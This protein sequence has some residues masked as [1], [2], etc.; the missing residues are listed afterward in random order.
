M[1]WYIEDVARWKAERQG[2]EAFGA[3]T[4]W[5]EPLGW[6]IDTNTRLI[7]DANITAGGM[8]WPVF[9]R[10][11]DFF[12]HSPP[13]VFP[14]G[15]DTRWSAHQYGP[16]GELCLEY[17]PDT[18]TPDLTGVHVME[19]AHRLLQG[20]NPAPGQTGTV[21]SRH[22]ES[23]GEQFR[24]K[25]I[26]FLMTRNLVAGFGA[27][28]TG[29][30]V[31][32]VLI[33]SHHKDSIIHTV[34]QITLGDGSIWI[35]SDVPEQL[36]DEYLSR[37]IPLTRIDPAT[38]LPPTA[39]RKD[40]LA[41]SVSFDFAPDGH[42]AIILRGDEVH[43]YML[44]ESDDWAAEVPIIPPQPIHQR[45]DETHT[46]L[47]TKKFGLVGC[48]SLG[49]KI[50]AMLARSGTGKALLVDDD[51]LLADNLARHDLDWRDVGT[52]KVDAVARRLQLANP[53]IETSIWKMRIGGQT[54]ASSAETIIN[55]LGECDVIIDA[56]A[57]PNVLNLLSALG[58]TK[59]K[60]LV[61]GEVFGGGIGGLIARFRPGIEPS[62]QYMRR[63][64][65][66]WFGEQNAPPVRAMRSYE[67]G[68]DGPPLIADDADV[69]VIAAHVARLAIDL[70]AR[71][72]SI[73]PNSVYAVGLG[74]GS[75][76]TQ[77][78]DTRPINVGPPPTHTVPETLGEEDR[79]AEIRKIVELF[80]ALSNEAPVA[81][82][83]N[84]TPAA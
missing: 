81:S 80:I 63:A 35:E 52:H 62:P 28:Q 31:S 2:L 65:E 9:L 3:A 37:R 21:P 40:F 13:S 23:I 82:T 66:N 42:Y 29:E 69:S 4:E 77:P 32:A 25:N 84:Q 70:L 51:L 7:L 17:G 64:I 26:R 48:G 5:F 74:A 75:V 6:R 49:S 68:G 24:R 43:H 67:T 44:W 73:F 12:P 18:W 78:F 55:M 59:S 71:D 11:P 83:D 30:S 60:P 34:Q 14:R 1:T 16:G 22:V 39:S 57:N 33:S 79:K 41:A 20:E 54:S 61:W 46:R 15:D 53:A 72:S 27:V 45:L 38:P 19:S 10:F 58:A 8:T 47:K 36:S 50:A 56:T 76:F